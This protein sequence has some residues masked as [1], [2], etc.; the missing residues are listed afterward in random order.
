MLE[1]GIIVS[2]ASSRRWCHKFGSCF[3]AE[4]RRQRPR[5]KDK[6]HLDAVFIKMGGRTYYLWRAVDAGGT[7]LDILV[8]ERRNQE[9]AETFLRRVVEEYPDA[10]CVVVTDKLAS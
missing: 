8:Q 3:A 1:R 2:Y 5:P 6:W 4:I 10:P 9:A 7:V